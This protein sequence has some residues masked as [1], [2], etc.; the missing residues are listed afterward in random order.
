MTRAKYNKTKIVATLGPA[1]NNY[2][3]LKRM[4]QAGVDVC[5]INFS[6]GTHEEH[7]KTFELVRKIDQEL[8]T[9]IC[10]LGDLQGPKLRIGE[11]EKGTI[12]ET[13]QHLL[14]T[15]KK[16]IGNA[17][18]VYVNYKKLP[19][20]INVG[21]KILIDDGKIALEVLSVP[22]K[23]L[24]NTIV[25]NGGKLSSRKGFN[26]PNTNVSL[27]CLTPKDKLDL[28][29]ALENGVDWVGLSFVRSADDVKSLKRI[30]ARHNPETL[31]IAKIEKPQAVENL[32]EIIAVADGLM[33]ARGDLGV[34]MPMERVPIIQ[35]T[36]VDKCIKASKPVIIATQMMES[37]IDSPTPTRAEASDVANAV[38]DGADAVMLSAETSVGQFPLETIEAVERI[39]DTT[40]QGWNIYYKGLRPD[41][42]SP[43][44]LSDE[45]CF[46]AVRMSDHINAKAIIT[47]T[48]SG[49]TAFKIASY[50]PNCDIFIF[51]SNR[52]IFR[53]L[54]LVWN[55]RVFYYNKMESTDRTMKDVVKFLKGKKFLSKGD[56]V[57][58]TASMPIHE[59]RR[60]NALKIG[61]VE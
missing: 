60:T 28:Q 27:P 61:K 2:A 57:V 19:A 52:K 13:G 8:N 6:H 43:S 18:K 15:T 24:I 31:V 29:F 36:I 16:C 49:Y 30:I 32:D 56:L 44:F 34:E 21:E 35:K 48:Q 33:V 53:I 54:S 20:D 17:E 37:M 51:T 55:V 41:E 14:V 47:L 46:T 22:G 4:V 45:I 58:H 50:R 7:L 42:N 26:L 3:M 40:E 5:R 10:V 11:I 59:K 39:V 25:L 1:T 12:L 23:D 38:M 9:N